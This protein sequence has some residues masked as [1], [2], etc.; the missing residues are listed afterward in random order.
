MKVERVYSQ[1]EV[2]Y[3]DILDPFINSK[4]EKIINSYNKKTTTKSQELTKGDDVI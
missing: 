2:N 1:K 3:L 4:I